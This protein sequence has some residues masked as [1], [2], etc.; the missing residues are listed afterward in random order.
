MIGY[1]SDEKKYRAF[2]ENYVDVSFL[3]S[4]CGADILCSP[5]SL[6]CK[7]EGMLAKHLREGALLVQIKDGADLTASFEDG[8]MLEYTTRSHEFALR[9]H[10]CLKAYQR[11]VLPIG[12][13]IGYT[14]DALKIDTRTSV[15]SY[16]R[17]LGQLARI[18]H[19]GIFVMPYLINST[20][21]YWCLEMLERHAMELRESPI[22]EFVVMPDD[23]YEASNSPMQQLVKVKD[24]RRLLRALGLSEA[25]TNAV[26][27][28]AERSTVKALRMVTSEKWA[29]SKENTTK[30]KNGKVANVRIRMGMGKGE[31][32]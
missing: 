25:D 6:P 18:G 3:E 12:L 24:G 20:H 30:I 1:D 22:K 10:I 11:I 5:L 32:L 19:S 26:W 8:R 15:M 23:M 4:A 17:F 13:Y 28:L 27:E 21:L 7:S 16:H 31:D 2:P 14:D 9:H 29:R